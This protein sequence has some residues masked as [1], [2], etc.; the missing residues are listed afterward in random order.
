MLAQLLPQQVLPMLLDIYEPGQTPMPHAEEVVA[1]GIDLGTTNT[2]VSVFHNDKVETFSGLIPSVV[3]YAGDGTVT[4]GK[5][6]LEHVG[7][8]EYIAVRSAKRLMGKSVKDIEKVGGKLPFNFS[9]EDGLVRIIAFDKKITPV[10]VSAEILREAKQSAEDYLGR[11][12]TQAVITVPAYFD[13]AA[14]Q[15]T[16]IAASMAGIDVLRLLAE[17]T[18]AALA[19]G[20]DNGIEGLYAVYDLGGGTFDFSL[21]KLEKGVFRV[22]ATGGDAALGGDD[23]DKIIAEKVI[24][25]SAKANHTPCEI[26][27]ILLSSRALKEQLSKDEYA[28]KDDFV[29]SRTEFEKMSSRLVQKTFR[30]IAEVLEN[31][32]Y[33]ASDIKGVVMVGGSTRIP[34]V[35]SKAQEFFGSLPLNNLN[36]DEIVAAGAAIQAH[37]L[38]AGSAN[39]LMDVTPLSLGLETMGGIVEKL[40]YR[41]TPIPCSVSQEFTTYAD[42]QNG[43]VIH[44]LQGEREM[45]SQCRSLARFELKGIPAMPAGVARIKIT[46]TI[47]ADGLLSVIAAE[48]NTGAVQAVEVKPSFGLD[49]TEIE[50][51][52][53]DSFQNAN[54]DMEARLLAETQME[55][56]RNILSLQ[57]A[58]QRHGHLLSVEESRVLQ[59]AIHAMDAAMSGGRDAV[60]AEMI[61]MEKI[62][63]NFAA[64]IM[65]EGVKA[66]IKGQTVKEIENNLL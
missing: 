4:V 65:D 66:A 5:R 59:D 38:V 61:R 29:I 11:K 62:S 52:L 64:K 21:L 40:I 28:Q 57:G 49:I 35:Q 6:A 36:P 25:D 24:I 2:V 12:V 32:G 16:K 34:L 48:Q 53:R 30:I 41:N 9:H 13:D 23:F 55:A 1:I 60:A 47:D 17:P 3:S 58:M 26:Q 19:Y 44:V 33:D 56:R 15:A 27:Q 43:M 45:V 63:Q 46:F 42:N 8:A 50:E 54:G 10:E 37:S 31:A 14:R 7:N 22:I 51:M 20:L 18:A 39:L